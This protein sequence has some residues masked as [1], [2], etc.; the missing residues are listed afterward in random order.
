MEIKVQIK[1]AGKRR[2]ALQ[3]V[4]YVLPNDIST[5]KDL[6]TALVNI[7]AELYNS[8]EPDTQLFSFL[9]AEQIDQ[10][11][12]AGKVGFGRI[13][14]E[15]RVETPKAVTVALLGF[16][17]GLYR[18]LV[19]SKQINSLEEAVNLNNGDTLTFIR[20]TFLAGRMF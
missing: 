18:V 2:K 8:Q 13:Y 7:E 6:I 20:L 5:L 14:S 10:M 16:E 15:T 12:E 4:P 9:T 1:S 19:N 3:S 17:D 11:S